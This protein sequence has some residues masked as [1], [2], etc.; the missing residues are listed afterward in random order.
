[1]IFGG[2]KTAVFVDENAAVV[3]VRADDRALLRA[4]NDM[5]GHAGFLAQQIA[6]PAQLLEMTRRECAEETAGYPQIGVERFVGDD[7]LQ[8]VEARHRFAHQP[9]QPFGRH[10]ADRVSQREFLS[11]RHHAAAARAAPGTDF[12]C[13]E[14]GRRCALPCRLRCGRQTTIAA[15]DDRHID[16]RRQRIAGRLGRRRVPPVRGEAKVVVEEQC[17]GS[18]EVFTV[19]WYGSV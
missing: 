12:G 11:A 14:H 3:V 2:M 19:A 1:M 13:I 15:A 8:V 18:H 7:P 16:A 6:L 17:I 10:P 5:N 4:G 9:A